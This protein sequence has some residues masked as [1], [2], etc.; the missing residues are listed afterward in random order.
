M[1]PKCIFLSAFPKLIENKGELP[2]S[3]LIMGIA[4]RQETEVD[5]KEDIKEGSGR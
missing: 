1:T 4:I 3:G 5:I 2:T